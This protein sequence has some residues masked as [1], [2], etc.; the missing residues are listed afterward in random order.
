MAHIEYIKDIVSELFYDEYVKP[1][2]SHKQSDY[3]ITSYG[4]FLGI[5]KSNGR[6]YGREITRF[7]SPVP[8]TNKEYYHQV[9]L[10]D[11]VYCVHREVARHFLP[12]FSEDLQVCHYNE[13]L[14][15]PYLHSVHNLWM[16]TQSANMKD[17]Y[18]KGRKKWSN[19]F[20]KA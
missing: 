1:F 2:S 15:L 19:Q 6:S 16:G 18:A 17:A 12:N 11:K 20:G 14:E 7:L 9:R 13:D 8:V 3:F 4:R 10:P 5:C